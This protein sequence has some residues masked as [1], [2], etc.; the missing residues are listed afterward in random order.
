MGG[1]AN[2]NNFPEDSTSVASGF[3]EAGQRFGASKVS[4][5]LKSGTA[6]RRQGTIWFDFF[7]L[8]TTL[9]P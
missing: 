9:I 8:V 2:E 4:E 3:S 1:S 5:W 6:L 7:R